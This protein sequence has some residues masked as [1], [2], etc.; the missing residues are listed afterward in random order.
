MNSCR[1]TALAKTEIRDRFAVCFSD[2]FKFSKSTF[3]VVGLHFPFIWV[4]Y[5]P[6]SSY[7]CLFSVRVIFKAAVYFCH[8]NVTNYLQKWSSIFLDEIKVVQI[9]Y[10]FPGFCEIRRFSTLFI[11][12]SPY[13]VSRTRKIYSAPSRVISSFILILLP[14]RHLFHLSG[15]YA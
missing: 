5:V 14:H 7:S 13:F 4:F 9:F 1:V 6:F 8:I 11:G 15:L 10:K 12:G 2:S 3:E